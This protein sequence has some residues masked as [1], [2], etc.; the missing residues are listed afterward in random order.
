MKKC[1][2]IFNSV[3]R[4]TLHLETDAAVFT[5]FPFSMNRVA[6]P[7]KSSHL[8]APG[9]PQVP[10]FSRGYETDAKTKAGRWR[11]SPPWRAVMLALGLMAAVGTAARGNTIQPI[12]IGESGP[13]SSEYTYT[14]D[15]ELTPNNYLQNDAT[16]PTGYPSSLTILDF[17]VVSG[18]PTLSAGIGVDGADVTSTSDWSVSTQLTGATSPLP[19]ASYTPG[20]PGTFL[21][22][23]S[24]SSIAGGPDS[25]TL[26]NI[27]LEYTGAG[28]ATSVDQRSL[29]QLKIVSNLAPG[30]NPSSVSLDGDPFTSTENPD[31]YALSTTTIA[32]VPE[33]A[34]V[35]L[36]GIAGVG[37]LLRRRRA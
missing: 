30:P 29:I 11:T 31:T 10:P 18:T 8:P 22:T 3:Y 17:G 1:T 34:S 5:R 36:L 24:N 12:L 35:S 33:P 28:L 32:V 25:S 23:G 20:S 13:V 4:S 14:Y 27:T 37:L 15:I 21:L 16:T 26:T 2:A 6:M 19:D 7:E 9:H